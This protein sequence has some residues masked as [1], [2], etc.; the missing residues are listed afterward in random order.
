MEPF[1]YFFRKEWRKRLLFH[2]QVE[3]ILNIDKAVISKFEKG[4][5][6]PLI[7]L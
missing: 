1:G 5:K 6:K 2:R 7:F 3:V 4:E